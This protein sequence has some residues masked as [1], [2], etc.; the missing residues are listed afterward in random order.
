MTSFSRPYHRNV[1]GHPV[2]LSISTARPEA[3]FLTECSTLPAHSWWGHHLNA[4]VLSIP[5]FFFLSG[6]VLYPLSS[7]E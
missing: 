1:N 5:F 4:D 2:V 3:V 7:L 6:L